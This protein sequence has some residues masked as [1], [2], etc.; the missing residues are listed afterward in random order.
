MEKPPVLSREKIDE[1]CH[2]ETEVERSVFVTVFVPNPFGGE[3]AEA[4]RDADVEW[5]EKWYQGLLED[6]KRIKGERAEL[7]NGIEQA[8]QEVAREVEQ[9]LQMHL[10]ARPDQPNATMGFNDWMELKKLL[11]KYIK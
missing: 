4:Q 9:F 5:Y 10:Y 6:Y 11:A 1:L 2:I 7:L 8:R 3:I